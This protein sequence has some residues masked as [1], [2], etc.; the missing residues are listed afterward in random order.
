[1]STF[2]KQ[3]NIDKLKEYNNPVDYFNKYGEFL[4]VFNEKNFVI[5]DEETVS[6]RRI[7][8]PNHK[9]GEDATHI[10]QNG[11]VFNL[12]EKEYLTKFEALTI[13]KFDNN[14]KDAMNYV[15]YRVL[16]TQVPFIRVGTDYFKII[17]KTNRYNV[18]CKKIKSWKKEEIREDYGKELL[19]DIPKFDDFTILPNNKFYKEFDGNCYNLYSKFPHTKVENGDF[20][21]ITKLMNHIFGEHLELGYKYMKILYENP[22]QILPVLVLVSN[23]RQTGKTTFLN[24]LEIIFAD[25][26]VMIAPSDL[27]NQFNHLYATKNIIAIDETVIDKQASVEKLKT[28]AT[29]KSM[30]VNQK[31]ISQY[32][33]PFFGKVVIATNKVTD[34]MRID[35]EEIRFWVRKIHPLKEL[36]TDIEE[37]LRKE[38]PQFLMYLESLPVI[39]LHNSRMVFTFDEIKTEDLDAVM[40][41]SHSGLRKELQ[42]FIEN[43]FMSNDVE[44]FEATAID[45]KD[46]FFNRDNGVSNHYVYKVLTKELKLH[47]TEKVIRYN[48]FNDF[49]KK[50]GKPFTFKKSQFMSESVN[51]IEDEE[52][53]NGIMF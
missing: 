26:Y 37:S 25:N 40:V 20:P 18:S 48:P 45:L 43:Y 10:L 39:D 17:H 42:I 22:M 29:Q 2:F 1:M 21:S 16:K 11:M 30:M 13:F 44:Y 52:D 41:E 19:K 28:I 36:N 35:E 24:F 15:E 51:E 4:S 6:D 12:I 46:R 3:E 9:N 31:N 34:F 8:V 32:V 50:V 7:K 23:E 47:T 5:L 33:I 53:S 38:I 14:Y 49:D 27:N